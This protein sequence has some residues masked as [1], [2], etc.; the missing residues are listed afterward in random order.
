MGNKR[1]VI[2]LDSVCGPRPLLGGSCAERGDNIADRE[3]DFKAPLAGSCTLVPM[4]RRDYKISDQERQRR[5]EL[6]KRLHREGRL[7]TQAQA[8]RAAVVRH[9]RNA[10]F[11]ASI[12]LRHAAKIERA[13]VAGLESD[14]PSERARMVEIVLKH[15]LAA[16][17]L[18]VMQGRAESEAMDRET[19]IQI[20]ASKLSNGV[21]AQVLRARM[22]DL[23]ANGHTDDAIPGQAVEIRR[24]FAP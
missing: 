22:A 20:L 3:G 5:S 14:K 12:A 21:T 1:Y 9:T 17:R 15:S 18:G 23:S 2:R 6:A 19:A 16:E 13:I 7:G 24:D 4:P 10:D 8:R 11:I